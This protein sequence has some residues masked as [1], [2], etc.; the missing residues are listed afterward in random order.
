MIYIFPITS[1][2]DLTDN[3]ELSFY[4]Q[5]LIN[6]DVDLHSSSSLPW[7]SLANVG[8]TIAEFSLSVSIEVFERIYFFV[9]TCQI[10]VLH[11]PCGCFLFSLS[12][13]FLTWKY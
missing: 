11:F 10:E 2:K 13:Y 9:F 7:A 12:V 6:L 3:E 8:D 5:C 1:A 4:E